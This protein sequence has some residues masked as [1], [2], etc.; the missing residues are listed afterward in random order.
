VTYVSEF[1]IFYV[2]ADVVALTIRDERLCALVVR[3]GESP[4]KGRW[5]LPG[6]F[7]RPDED[8]PDAAARELFEETGVRTDALEQLATYGSPKRD[9][10]GRIVSVAYLA[11]I[12]WA[13][14][15]QAGSDAADAEWRAVD[16]LLAPRQLAFDHTTI[17]TDG[18][19]RARS[20]LEYTNLATSFVPEEFTITEL[21]DVYDVIWGSDLDAGNFHRKVVTG[22]KGFVEQTGRRREGGTGRPARTFRAG[23]S[24]ALNPPLTRRSVAEGS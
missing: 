3:R 20:K 14:E 1:P 15:A 22:T 21:R 2:T 4:Y 8:L 12:P 17:L 19:E 6:G 7:V 24:P 13:P 11:V 16:S 18:V 23:P 5:A 9:P 10:R